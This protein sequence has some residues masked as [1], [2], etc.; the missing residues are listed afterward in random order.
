MPVG[1]TVLIKIGAVDEL[2]GMAASHPVLRISRDA[3]FEIPEIIKARFGEAVADTIR[4]A[5]NQPPLGIPI[6]TDP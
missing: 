1:N 4:Q 6:P 3:A 5:V 2:T